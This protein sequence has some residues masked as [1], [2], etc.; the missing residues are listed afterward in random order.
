MNDPSN[1]PTA[2]R[3]LATQPARP[4]GLQIEVTVRDLIRRKEAIDEMMREILKEDVHFGASFPGDKKKNLLQPGADALIGLFGLSPRFAQQREDFVIDGE[5]TH[6]EYTVTCTLCSRSG[7]ELGSAMGSCTTLES[8]YRWRNSKKL[9]PVCHKDTVIK[10][11]SEYGGGWLCFEKKGGCN[12]KWQDG[13][14]AIEAQIVGKVPNPDI[15]DVFNT[16]LKIAQKRA[17]VAAVILVTGCADMFTQDIEDTR[18]DAPAEGDDAGKAQPAAKTAGTGAG[19]RQGSQAPAKPTATTAASA[20]VKAAPAAAPAVQG[21]ADEVN[22]GVAIKKEAAD[23]MAK[24]S[25]VAGAPFAQRAWRDTV[26]PAGSP[27]TEATRLMGQRLKVL[28]TAKELI[29][30]V[31]REGGEEAIRKLV[32]DEKY[33]FGD[34]LIALRN[35][36]G[37]DAARNA[38]HDQDEPPF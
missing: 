12:A 17:K 31:I 7:D 29:D 30:H 35:M 2:E 14:P 11:K 34:A 26:I 25:T 4:R 16:V 13:D 37:I 19:N 28:R 21:T 15:A 10:G 27:L 9:C 1:V 6:R 8:K 5:G 32:N 22:A 24:L 18:G 38:I 23:A 33:P 3:E 20:P 36:A